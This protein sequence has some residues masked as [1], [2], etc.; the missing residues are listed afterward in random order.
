MHMCTAFTWMM[1]DSVFRKQIRS[2]FGVL[3]ALR[4][5]VAPQ[6]SSYKLSIYRFH[7]YFHNFCS[8][9]SSISS[10]FIFFY[11]YFNL[12]YF[13]GHF[14]DDIDIDIVLVVPCR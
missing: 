4:M 2:H 11:F 9:I 10:F 12:F 6:I 5:Q 14:P 13:F 3:G 8:S 7:V 1:D